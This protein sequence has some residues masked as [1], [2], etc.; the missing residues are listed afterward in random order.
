MPPKSPVKQQHSAPSS[1][2]SPSKKKAVS[3]QE[4]ATA[5]AAAALAKKK[6]GL[7]SWEKSVRITSDAVSA[8]QREKRKQKK[9]AGLPTKRL[10]ARGK[11]KNAYRAIM[12]QAKNKGYHVNFKVM[13]R[14]FED[15]MNRLCGDDPKE[16]L[17]LSRKAHLILRAATEQILSERFARA[18]RIAGF[19]SGK[20][21]VSA[22][23]LQVVDYLS[24]DRWVIGLNQQN[25]KEYEQK[26]AE[27]EKQIALELEQKREARLKAKA[28]QTNKKKKKQQN[29]S[30]ME[31]Q[32]ES[33]VVNESQQLE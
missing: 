30:Q 3:A 8:K 20:P 28:Q 16:R 6:S 26:F 9:E 33:N 31:D 1:Q 15:Q 2:Q 29:S 13:C 18:N 19:Y 21:T 17:H 27:E 22:K 10:L 25:Q 14:I 24:Q 4:V 32:D 11:N 7:K 5:A 23:T 12:R